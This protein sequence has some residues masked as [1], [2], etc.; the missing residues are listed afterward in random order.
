VKDSLL[1]LLLFSLTFALVALFVLGAYF[2]YNSLVPGGRG[3]IFA[4]PW[5]TALFPALLVGLIVAQYRSVHH[6]GRFLVTWIALAVAFF[7]LLSL[8]IPAIGQAASIRSPDA[9]PLVSGRFLLLEDNGSLLAPPGQ[10]IEG[11]FASGVL[12]IPGNQAPMSLLESLPYDPLNQRFLLPIDQGGAKSL[13]ETGP[14]RAYFGY[15]DFYRF[16]Q[17]DLFTVY[18]ALRQS[19]NSNATLYLAQTAAITGVFLGLFAF[20]SFRTWPL[21]Q[22]ILV[23]FMVRV[24]IVFLTYSLNGLPA[25]VAS[26]W[27]DPSTGYLRDW[28]P[29]AWMALAAATLLF[30]T[31][32]SKPH[33]VEALS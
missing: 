13:L 32:L 18:Q 5:A 11:Q 15:P 19:W 28:I 6:P 10:P 24:A 8:S 33:H 25:V 17:E 20:F 26:W 23:I 21:V 1:N 3:L 30:I 9:P 22:L 29:V 31:V 27:P 2:L 12:S 7:L 4:S 14:E 16:L